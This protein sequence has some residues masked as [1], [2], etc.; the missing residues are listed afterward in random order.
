M[1]IILSFTQNTALD[2]RAIDLVPTVLQCHM[3]TAGSTENME[4]RQ[5]RSLTPVYTSDDSDHADS[6]A[7]EEVTIYSR[8]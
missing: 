7:T 5:V 4:R 8:N 1:P 3:D 6:A 2:H